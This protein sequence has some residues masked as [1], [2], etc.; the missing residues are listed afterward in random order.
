MIKYA[1]VII[2]SADLPVFL[3]AFS[4]CAIENN[5]LGQ[6]CAGTIN[7]IMNHEPVG[8][9]YIMALALA[10]LEMDIKEE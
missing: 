6:V 3:E 7:R 9:R 10:I 8:E 4:S 5:R 2:A 1:K